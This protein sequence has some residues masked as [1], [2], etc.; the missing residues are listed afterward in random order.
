MKL[1]SKAFK[2]GAAL[3]EKY[4]CEGADISPPLEIADVPD[5]AKSLVLIMDDHD[6]PLEISPTRSWDH[7]VVFN[8]PPDTKK[9]AEGTAPKGKIGKNSWGNKEYG[10]PCPPDKMH[11]YIISLYAI[12]GI[13][14]LPA[15]ANKLDVLRTMEGHVIANTQLMCTYVKKEN[16]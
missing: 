4:S 14:D 10:G 3:P 2:Q 9:I 5:H 11:R 8:I 13:L 16:K 12:D 15:G 6:V 7:W 1:T